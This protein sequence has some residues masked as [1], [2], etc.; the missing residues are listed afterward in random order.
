MVQN[1]NRRAFSLVELLVVIA[2]IGV[3]IAMLLPAVQAVREAAR[4]TTCLNNLR[5]VSIS[6]FNYESAF[7]RLPPPKL[8]HGDFNTLG[9]TFVILLPYVEQTGRFDQYR[10]D[11][12]ISSP[13]NL[14]LT[15]QPLDI[16]SCPTM[17]FHEGSTFGEGSYLI[18][19]A[20][21]YRPNAN[22]LTADGAFADPPKIGET[23]DLGFS[24]FVDGISNTIFFGEIDNSVIWTGTS[25]N[26]G[27]WGNHTWAQG[28]WF[29]S[30]SHLE[31][32]FNQT[33]PVD[34]FQLKEY[35][36]FRSD[37]PAIVNFVFADGSA[38]SLSESLSFETL[39]ALVTRQGGEVIQSVGE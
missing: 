34:E 13:S 21:R 37:H 4:K 28:Y 25:T 24:A 32:K 9:S 10:I 36:T 11:E 7:G 1:R 29:N 26:P 17:Q 16:Y 33:G 5:Q 35:R 30:M 31:G 3:L 12:S 23:Y 19:F 20:T 8:G 18:S 27:A 38:K 22:G 6:A 14:P 2:I 15:M 39:R